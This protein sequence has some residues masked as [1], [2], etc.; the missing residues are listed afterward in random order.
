MEAKSYRITMEGFESIEGNFATHENIYKTNESQIAPLN[1]N[2]DSTDHT[3]I[4]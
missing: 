1:L 3:V 4:A 2:A